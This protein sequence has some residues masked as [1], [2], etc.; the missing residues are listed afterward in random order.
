MLA[1]QVVNLTFFGILLSAI[2]I[3]AVSTTSFVMISVVFFIVRNAIGIQQTPPN[4]VLYA[5]TLILTAFITAPVVSDVFDRVTD[6]DLN[7]TT[8]AQFEDVASDAT[9]PIRTFLLKRT[10]E[11]ERRFFIAATAKVWPPEQA[12]TVSDTDLII[13]VPTF[14]T[15]ELNKAFKIGLLLYL[16][17]LIV[18]LVISAVLMA[19]GMIMMSPTI[20]AVPFK[21]ALFVLVDGWTRIVQGLILSYA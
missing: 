8:L 20:I 16:P 12:R 9:E 1:E 3:I 5:L 15:A 10:S 7:I 11:E 18:D 2:P 6:R 19:M 14:V 4:I 13:L 21:L 17:F